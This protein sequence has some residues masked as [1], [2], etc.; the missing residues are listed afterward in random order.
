MHLSARFS[1]LARVGASTVVALTGH[2]LF[3]QVYVSPNGHD[4]AN[5][6]RQHPVQTLERARDLA[7]TASNKQIVV[8]DG[9]YRLA[10][11][12]Q[13]SAADAGLSL[14]AAPNAHPVVSGGVRLSGWTQADAAKNLWKVHVP[15]SITNSRQMYIDGVRS[16]R[17]RGVLPVRLTMTATGYTA[18]ADTMSHWRNPSDIELAYT[19][20]NSV[21]NVRSQGL[22][23]WTEPRC[24]IASIQGAT[25]TMAEPCWSN[26][27][28]RVMLPSG[29]RTANLVGPKS[30]G[31]QPT[32]VE[33][34]YE[35]LGT[36][37]AFYFDR[38][39]HTLYYT[40]REGEHMQTADVELPVLETLL[41][42]GGTPA[43]PVENIRVE[44]LAFEYATW[45]FPSTPEGFS[46]IQA[47]YLVTGPHG[48]DQQGLCDLVPGGACPF[49]AWTRAHGN[50]SVGAGRN[51]RFVRDTFTHLGAAGLDLG[52]GT[53]DSQVEG[54]VFTDISGNGLQLGSV[55][56]PLAPIAQFTANNRIDNNVFRNVGAE[57]RDGIGIVIGYARSTTVEHNELD[58]L[59]YA[60]ISIGWGGWPDKIKL[61]G[62][63]N[64]SAHNVIANNRIHDFMLVLSDGGGI[65]TQG[66]TGKDL[67]DGERIT[68]N[69]ITDQYS[70]GH[71]I[72]TDNGSAMITISGN[73][74]FKANHDD[75]NSKHHDYYDGAKG[76]AFNPLAIENNYY[77]Q[78]D[79][80]S[81]KQQVRYAGNRLI[82]SLTAA[83]ADVLNNAG[84]QPGFRDVSAE[85]VT[86]APEPPSR[87]A[88]FG[89][90]GS[91]Y[92]T[93]SPSV[94]D[95]GSPVTSY[96]V[97]ASDGKTLTV[98]AAE[99]L[100]KAYAEMPGLRNGQSYTFTVKAT[101]ARGTSAASLP[102]PA[103][104]VRPLTI[105]P[106]AAPAVASAFVD[107]NVVSIHFQSPKPASTHHDEA[108]I[109]AYAVTVLSSGRKVLLTGRNVIALQEGT[110]TTFS[111]LELQAGEKPSFHVAA[112][113]AAGEGQ[114]LTVDAQPVRTSA[115]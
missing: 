113:N 99:F 13:L 73:V 106:P 61:P 78:G 82:H 41:D 90:D 68:G 76:E 79:R 17:T 89:R 21:W 110:H 59:P 67:S 57:Y 95:G 22:G 97:V 80:D 103:V 5:G 100:A 87:V 16:H 11:P 96:T 69:V 84:P 47:N 3:A 64:N 25:I 91:A 70:S 20:G 93:W 6:S 9:V 12:L 85:H 18:D 32:F 10:H 54:C 19:G 101:N 30:I 104:D 83:P 39:S 74:V 58:H 63:A 49:G 26:S 62:Q 46:E 102:S 44:G 37:G 98:P 109:T 111:T 23:S 1:R 2:A 77:E 33:N 40:P 71:G 60:A 114:P 51:L 88:S 42:I 15:E 38:P 75:I 107:G 115:Q 92:I 7:R 34:A 86:T 105:E 29:V 112:V 35:L 43:Q 4:A 8:A 24:P 28:Q 45:L 81:D 65:Y 94:F 72:Y 36:P 31:K 14:V 56:T 52:A 27:T 108:P 50:V 48:F 66:R 55:D 53:Q